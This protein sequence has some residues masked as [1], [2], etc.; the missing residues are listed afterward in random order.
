[1]KIPPE[2]L[3]ELQL[4][5]NIFNAEVREQLKLSSENFT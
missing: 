5:F 2:N 3:I 1:M 4:C